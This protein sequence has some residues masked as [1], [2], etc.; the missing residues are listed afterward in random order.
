[1][2]A[3][4]RRFLGW[5]GRQ[6]I[7]EHTCGG[8]V[9]SD[10]QGNKRTQTVRAVIS[11]FGAVVRPL[12]EFFRLEASSGIV[13]F[14]AA[15]LALVWAN[16]DLHA[17]YQQLFAM[18]I[19]VGFGA[20]TVKVSVQAVINDGLMA[21]FFLLVGMEIKRELVSGELRTFGQAVLPAVAALGGMVVPSAIFLI[22]NGQ[23]PARQGWGIPM[24]TDIAFCIGCLTLLGSRVPNALKVFLVALAIFDDIGGILVIAFFYGHGL[25]LGWL[26]AAGLVTVALVGMNRLNVRNG[27]AY[28][29]AGGLLWYTLHAGGIHATIAGVVLGLII[30]A[31][32]RRRTAEVL[33]DLAEHVQRL[34]GK[35]DELDDAA[36]LQI[37]EKLE[38]LEAP[39]T[40]FVHLLHPW[41]AFGIMPLFALANSGVRFGPESGGLGASVA[42]GVGLGLLLGK[43]IGIMLATFIGVR[44][45]LA[46]RPGD[47]SWMRVAGVSIIGGIGFTVALFIA[48]LAYPAHPVL[49]DQAKLGI[50]CGSALAGVAGMTVLL[51]IP[52]PA[53]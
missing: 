2:R 22:F 39:L 24:A 45:G 32:P 51:I 17:S 49:L 26:L 52:R 47:A 4:F 28:V 40:R 19:T 10:T 31:R 5:S 1:V 38:D 48:S 25:A 35:R 21:V 9:V 15:V 37:E 14:S 30:P 42:L 7:R 20:A 44:L 27:L 34:L 53:R 46:P 3:P 12:Q 33:D 41:V 8:R 23:A 13:L 16:S 29:A 18:P 36:I 6:P 11:T 43:P 50:L